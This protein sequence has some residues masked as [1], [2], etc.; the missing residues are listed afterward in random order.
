MMRTLF[1]LEAT[2]LQAHASVYSA[3]L[4]AKHVNFER[5][6]FTS[7]K[8]KKHLNEHS[9]AAVSVGITCSLVGPRLT[10]S[11]MPSLQRLDTSISHRKW[12]VC[13]GSYEQKLENSSKWYYWSSFSIGPVAARN[14]AFSNFEWRHLVNATGGKFILGEW[15][16]VHHGPWPEL[17]IISKAVRTLRTSIREELPWKLVNVRLLSTC[18]HAS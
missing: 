5:G 8:S 14:K 12:K 3:L 4:D 7:D 2:A 9:R 6:F 17:R 1:S 10:D 13:L 16:G 11:Q 18:K 15:H